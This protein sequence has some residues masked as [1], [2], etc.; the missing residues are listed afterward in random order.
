MD[1]PQG[2]SDSPPMALPPDVP[3]SHN[4][5]S[6]TRQP[7]LRFPHSYRKSGLELPVPAGEGHGLLGGHPK[8]VYILHAR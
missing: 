4:T 5:L 2:A 3:R 1:T 7:D 6:L 8:P